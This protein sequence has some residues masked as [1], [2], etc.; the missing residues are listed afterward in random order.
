MYETK[1][2]GIVRSIP[3]NHTLYFIV[4]GSCVIYVLTCTEWTN[5]HPGVLLK[6]VV[7]EMGDD[8]PLKKDN[9]VGP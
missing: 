5:N 2:V 3:N 4:L 9:C 8:R 1:F 6:S 7:S